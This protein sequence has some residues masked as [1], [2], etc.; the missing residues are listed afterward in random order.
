MKLSKSKSLHKPKNKRK[1]FGKNKSY[2]IIKLKN[3]KKNSFKKNKHLNLKNKSFRKK[4]KY[5]QKGGQ[6]GKTPSSEQQHNDDNI[7]SKDDDL[8]GNLEQSINEM[9][10][11]FSD[12]SPISKYLYTGEG[13]IG[14]VH[15]ITVGEDMYAVL[16]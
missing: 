3:K 14:F 5:K 16:I 4:R 6:D 9:N 11:I 12:I 10:E 1:R 2:R 13:D 7:D 15:N 8:I